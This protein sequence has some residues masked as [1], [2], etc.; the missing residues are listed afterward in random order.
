M[1]MTSNSPFREQDVRRDTGGRFDEHVRTGP[2]V[3]LDSAPDWG[4]AHIEEGGRTPW[5]SADSVNHFAE[6]LAFASTPGHGGYKVSPERQKAIPSTMRVQGA[7]YEEDVEWRIAAL[8]HPEAFT[9]AGVEVEQARSECEQQVKDYFPDKWEATYGPLEPGESRTKDEQLWGEAHAGDYVTTSALRLDDGRV[10][11]TA[12]RTATG[13]KDTFI[14]SREQHDAMKA[15]VADDRGAAHRSIV[16]EDAVPEPRPEPIEVPRYRGLPDVTSLTP[17]GRARVQK[18]LTQRWR[19]PETGEVRS[20]TTIIERDGLTGKAVYV[21]N[22]ARKYSLSV[23]SS[24][25]AVSKATWDAVPTPDERTPADKAL[26]EYHVAR[27]KYEASE[28]R[29]SPSSW[30]RTVA[31]QEQS[32]ELARKANAARAAWKELLPE[33]DIDK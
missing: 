1:S 5:G 7:W 25:Y 24:A 13:D 20:L 6:G 32:S 17:T 21:E 29:S 26:T 18:D 4:A 10:Q 31:R 15:G 27:D 3:T 33:S 22:G 8:Y 19:N 14:L 12:T 30:A 9:S 16:P 23:G 11:V 2:E 28:R